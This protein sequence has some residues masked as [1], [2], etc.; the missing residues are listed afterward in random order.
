MVTMKT[1]VKYSTRNII[2]ALSIDEQR[3]QRYY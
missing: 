3:W 1:D 2:I